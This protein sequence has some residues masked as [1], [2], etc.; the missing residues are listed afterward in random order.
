MCQPN[1]YALAHV[2]SKYDMTKKTIEP[3]ENFEPKEII[4]D[5]QV[6]A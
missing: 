2:H 3:A 6:K 5:L 4:G 1:D